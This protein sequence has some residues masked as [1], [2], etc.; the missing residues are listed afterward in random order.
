VSGESENILLTKKA[1]IA[2]QV[3]RDFHAMI[4]LEEDLENL[5]RL[6]QLCVDLFP[7]TTS[8]DPFFVHD[9]TF[10]LL[11]FARFKSDSIDPS[12]DKSQQE[13]MAAEARACSRL[14]LE[15]LREL[16]PKLEH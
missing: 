6:E 4:E 14:V 11:S 3:I 10:E 2:M 9:Y 13:D 8:L 5:R 12:M 16:G 7:L 15:M 1:R